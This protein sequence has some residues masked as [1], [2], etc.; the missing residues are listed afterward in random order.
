MAIHRHRQ[1]P[2]I[3]RV[4][5]AK[6]QLG[7]MPDRELAAKIG[8]SQSVLSHKRADLGISPFVRGNGGSIK[9][10]ICEKCKKEGTVY[11]FRKQYLCD[12]CML[13]RE[14][15]IEPLPQRS[16]LADF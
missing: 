3:D 8:V 5:A 14:E 11:R 10:G 16:M 1:S 9:Y 2:Q 4:L 7:K 13:G 12:R 6:N 15:P